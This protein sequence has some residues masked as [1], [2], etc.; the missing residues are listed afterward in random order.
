M[1]WTLNVFHFSPRLLFEKSVARISIV[2]CKGDYRRGLDL[3]LTLLT[4]Y[5][6]TTHDYTLQVTDAQR[7]VSSVYYNLH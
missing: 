1:Y 7:L 6:L 3:W 2:I 5:T 4:S